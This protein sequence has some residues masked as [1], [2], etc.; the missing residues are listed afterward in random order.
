MLSYYRGYPRRRRRYG[1]RPMGFNGGRRMPIDVQSD[2]EAYLIT[3]AVPGLS[4]EDVTVEV[5]DDLV[6][7]S[8][9][10]TLEE[11]GDDQ[12]LLSELNRSFYRQIRLPE[13]VNADEIEAKVEKGLLTVR[14]PKADEARP[15][16]IEVK[17]E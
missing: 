2:D 13:S 15:R 16:K 4:A 12:K 7:M 8:G 9:E 1:Y 17:A 5:L 14:V 6:T 11:N 10:I 3:A